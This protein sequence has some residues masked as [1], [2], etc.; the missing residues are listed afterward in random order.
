METMNNTHSTN[1]GIIAQANL[2]IRHLKLVIAVA[3]EGSVTKAGHRLHLT[4]SALSHQ[5]REAERQLGASLFLRLNKKMILTEAGERLLESAQSVL[6][7]LKHAGEEIHR[8]AASR[9]SVLRIST[10]CYTCYHWLPG[11]LK[12]FNRE[13]PRVDVQIVVEATRRPIQALLEGKLDLAI[14]SETARNGKL[15]FK[16]LFRDELVVVM[17]PDH[18]LASRAHVK[19]EDFSGE[20]LIIY[21]TSGDN[22]VIQKV[23]MPSGISPRRVSQVQLTEAIFEMV[24]AGLGITVM[25]RWAVAPQIESGALA[26]LPLTNKGFHRQWRAALIKSKKVPNYINGFVR[27]LA[28]KSFAAAFE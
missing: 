25:A 23:L 10:E 14:V 3:E 19:P 5:L 8:M 18:P 24:K 2:E 12:V 13:F 4:Q 11:M 6:E 27:L 16:P 15:L 21:T 7:E 17:R 28:N 26:A 22:A 9:D 20:H 1:R